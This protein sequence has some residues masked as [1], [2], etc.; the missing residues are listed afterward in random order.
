MKN[1]HDMDLIRLFEEI[2]EPARDELFVARVS[3]RMVL[4]R[5]V[6]RV[7]QILITLTGAVILAVL[8]PRLMELIGYITLGSS[9]IANIALALILSPVGWAIGGGVGLTFFLKTRS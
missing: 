2:R 9:L 1:D 8:T 3:K 5:Y 6:R 7:M 4:R